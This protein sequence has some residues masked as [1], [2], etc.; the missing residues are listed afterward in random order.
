G[1]L[2]GRNLDRLGQGPD[3]SGLAS[4][5][6]GTRWGRHELRLF[7]SL[8]LQQRRRMLQGRSVPLAQLTA[9]QRGLCLTALEELNRRWFP[10][11]DLREAAG[12]SFGLTTRPMLRIK[13]RHGP[14]PTFREEPVPT[15]GAPGSPPSPG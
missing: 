8:S 12:W 1:G 15:P 10:P 2:Q 7:A 13:D 6:A 14:F 5:G 11:L 4:D 3:R 9:A